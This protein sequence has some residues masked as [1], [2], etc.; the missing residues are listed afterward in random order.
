MEI[1]LGYSVSEPLNDFGQ[2]RNEAGLY[3]R[4]PLTVVVLIMVGQR[5]NCRRE[6][7]ISGEVRKEANAII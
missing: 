4:K 2:G 7:V 1:H 3:F 5:V 6:W